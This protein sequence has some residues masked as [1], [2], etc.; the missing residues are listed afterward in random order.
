MY[1]KKII[2][3]A[4]ISLLAPGFLPHGFLSSKEAARNNR[5]SHAKSCCCGHAAST[6]QNCGCSDGTNDNGKQPVTITSCGGTSNNIITSPR[7][8]YFFSQSVFVNYLPLT[9]LEETSTLQL[10]DV[11]DKPPYKP[12]KSQLLT[13]FI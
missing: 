13:N 8:N 11:L 10:K 7:I 4:I 9:T 6:C 12:P 5:V 3:L 2:I 1:K